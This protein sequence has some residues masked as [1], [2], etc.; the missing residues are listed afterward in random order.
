MKN[1]WW[2]KL[3]NPVDISSLI[4]FRIIFG[5]VMMWEVAKYFENGWIASYWIAPEFYFRYPLFEWVSP[6][7]GQGMYIHFA[8]LGVAS[9]FYYFRAFLSFFYD[10]VFSRF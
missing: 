9:S 3:F 1:S 7:P 8:V 10:S 2:L 6:W 5:M 4:Y